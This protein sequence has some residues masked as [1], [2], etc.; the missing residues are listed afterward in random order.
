MRQTFLDGGLLPISDVQ[1]CAAKDLGRRPDSG[2]LAAIEPLRVDEAA[3]T[4]LLFR[5]EAVGYRTG[6]SRGIEGDSHV[7][8]LTRGVAWML[9][10]AGFCLSSLLGLWCIWRIDSIDDGSTLFSW[11]LDLL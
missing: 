11:L 5:P 3:D 4:E 6:A 1:S 10:I 9:L 2:F 7:T 8:T